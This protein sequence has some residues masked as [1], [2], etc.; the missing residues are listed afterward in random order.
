VKVFSDLVIHLYNGFLRLYPRRFRIEFGEEMKIVFFDMVISANK[1]GRWEV[2]R[3]FLRELRDMPGLL[4]KLY[5]FE[6][7]RKEVDMTPEASLNF[8]KELDPPS[9]NNYLPGSAREAVLAG[10]PHMV[11]TLLIGFAKLTSYFAPS[12]ATRLL[13][14]IRVSTIIVLVALIF[15]ALIYAWKRNWPL[16]SA[17]WFGY[18]SWAAMVLLYFAFVQL[19]LT[20]NWRINNALVMSWLGLFVLAYSWLV[21]QNY[22]KAILAVFF[23]MPVYSL[24]L[25]EFVPDYIEGIL[26]IGL[27]LTVALAAGF[28]VRLNNP[29]A[30][31]GLALGANIFVGSVISY[32]SVYLIELPDGI[33]NTPNPRD[34]V[35]GMAVYSAAS[36]ILLAG[37]SLLWGLWD[38]TKRLRAA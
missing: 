38:F 16:W 28:I 17:S 37:P 30:G 27:G 29:L 32:I 11:F 14:I 8:S 33:P 5:W 22:L 3:L 2:A 23:L 21:R 34:V 26:A 20:E 9:N 4:F 10:L 15:G 6:M 31:F 18:A 1:M 24:A 19:G 36:L 7:F 35:I 12:L 25:L 13:P